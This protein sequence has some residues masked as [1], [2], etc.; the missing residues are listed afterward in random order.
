MGHVVALA[1]GVGAAKLLR[2]L[3]RV[4]SPEDL[5]IV[6]NVGD[7]FEFHGFHVSPDLDIVMYTLADVVDGARGWGI[8]DDSFSC[9]GMLGRLGFETWF[10]LGDKDIA[11]QMVRTDLLKNGVSLSEAV[12]ELCR[13]LGVKAR[14]L[15]MSNDPVRTVVLS[16]C[17]RLGFQEYFV[18]RRAS[19]EVTGVLFEG[20]DVARPAPGVI[21]AINN[22]ERVIVC[23]SNPIL[24]INPILSVPGVRDALK[25]TKGSVVAVSPIVGGK[26]VKGPADRIM[27]SLGLEA[28]AYGVAKL[29]EDFLDHLII[30]RADADIRTAIEELGVRVSVTDTLMKDV[31]SSASLAS[32]VMEAKR[33]ELPR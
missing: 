18:K 15:P 8:M 25:S 20:C 12:A 32:L 10:G 3:V 24:S 21:E 14:L 2:G 27:S 5:V 17:V 7:D 9:L 13:L 28:S 22:A 23:P 31:E 1:G 33:P 16:G 26:A 30:D 6:G 19:D 11:V 29:Y 4:V